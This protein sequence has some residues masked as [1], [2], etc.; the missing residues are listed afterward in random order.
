MQ[1]TKLFSFSIYVYIGFGILL[2]PLIPSW[3]L[4]IDF[5]L[6]SLSVHMTMAVIFALEKEALLHEFAQLDDG[7]QKLRVSTD[8]F[9]Q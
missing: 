4:A 7:Q 3:A 6:A 1:K 8:F 2:L 5:F 9:I